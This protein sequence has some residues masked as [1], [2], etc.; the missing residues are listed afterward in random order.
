MRSI[1]LEHKVMF[2]SVLKHPNIQG[3]LLPLAQPGFSKQFEEAIRMSGSIRPHPVRCLVTSPHHKMK[4]VVSGH[5]ARMPAQ[6][7]TRTG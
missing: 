1:T 3:M 6:N 4:R 2:G 5:E 7:S